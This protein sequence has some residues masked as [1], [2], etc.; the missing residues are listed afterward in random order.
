MSDS[1]ECCVLSG[2]GLYGPI[3]L[4]EE[5]YCVCVCV[6]VSECYREVMVTRRP[7]PTKGSC[8]MRGKVKVSTILHG[9]SKKIT[10]CV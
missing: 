3:T 6:H 1:C 7:W 10:E 9:K 2:R 8:T 5:S 4:T